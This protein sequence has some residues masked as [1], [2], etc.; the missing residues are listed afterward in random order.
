MKPLSRNKL[1][2]LVLALVLLGLGLRLFDLTDP[3]I[4]F[5]PTRQ[6]RGAIVARGIYYQLPGEK[7]PLP[8]GRSPEEAQKQAIAYQESTGQY[9]PPVLESLAALS[10]QV[11]G[12]EIPW[13]ARLYN[14]LFWAMG[15]LALFDLARRLRISA[16]PVSEPSGAILAGAIAAIGYFLLLPFS[17]QASRSFQ[18]DPGMVMWFIL[19]VWAL[20]HWSA[21]QITAAVKTTATVQTTAAVQATTAVQD[22]SSLPASQAAPLPHPNNQLAWKWAIA[23]GILGGAAVFSKAVAA[24]FLAG[25]AGGLVIWQLI[26]LR[27]S[28]LSAR[29][30]LLLQALCMAALMVV[31]TAI[32]TAQ[33]GGRASEYFQS[34]TIA[35]S[36]LLLQ[37]LTYLRWL[38][39]LQGL[40]GQV[41]SPGWLVLLLALV[42]VSAAK[43]RSRVLL[44]SL[45]SGY[46][47]YGL[48]FPYQMY[49]HS[50]Y[51]LAALPIVALCLASSVQ[52]LYVTFSNTR[53]GK[54][55]PILLAALALLW[56]ALASFTSAWQFAQEDHRHEPVY[57]QAIA[58][59]LPEQ[60]KIIALTQD[61][62]YRLMYYGWQKVTLW[63]NR[64]EQNV[65]A[66]RG[67]AKEFDQLFAKRTEGKSYFL[68]TSFNQFEDQPDLQAKLKEN[69]PILAQGQGYLIFDLTAPLH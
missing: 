56:A 10:Y 11:A 4:D 26:L 14:S 24:Y 52:W 9:E 44:L 31:P 38:D 30:Q 43:G 35:L 53:I 55:A 32:Y 18:P 49:S 2:W 7:A 64:G 19:T 65:M 61:Y 69:Y 45:W 22:L 67:N 66:L 27:K 47:L 57:W 42:G 40:L 1:L 25:A 36:H 33:Q 23:V 59:Q 41:Y 54:I 15:G 6:L 50:Y 34:W 48:F 37:P 39:S 28:P 29:I 60:G 17:V 3:P 62:G 13:I 63:P 5:H 16:L 21:V 58:S 8:P 46:L 12:Q 68:I 20:D 51:H